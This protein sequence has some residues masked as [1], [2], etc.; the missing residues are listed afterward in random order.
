MVLPSQLVTITWRLFVYIAGHLQPVV[1]FMG[2]LDS[3]N[4]FILKTAKNII[5][6]RYFHIVSS[7]TATKAPSEN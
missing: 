1:C 7:V 4:L 5:I 6:L 2:R 3:E